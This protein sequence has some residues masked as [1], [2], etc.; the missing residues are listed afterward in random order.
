MRIAAKR[1]KLR[2]DVFPDSCYFKRGDEMK[3]TFLLALAMLLA[4]GTDS[5]A[6]TTQKWTAGWDNFSEAL[7]FTHSNIKWAVSPTPIDAHL[8]MWA[9]HPQVIR[10]VST[11]CNTFPATS[12][13]FRPSAMLTVVVSRS[14]GK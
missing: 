9:R 8:L 1:G 7:D 5:A 2:A 12:A 3:M 14:R 4:V 11:F 6:V 13:S 10:S